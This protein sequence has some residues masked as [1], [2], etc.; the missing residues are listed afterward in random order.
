MSSIDRVALVLIAA[1]SMAACERDSG[2][3]SQSSSPPQ[4]AARITPQMDAAAQTID[5]EKLRRVIAEISDDRYGGRLPGTEGDTLARRYLAGE[6][7]RLGFASGAADGG[8]EQPVEL[9]GI[10]AQAPPVWRFDRGGFAVELERSTDF[11]AASGVQAE[12]A[13]IRDAELV[14]AGYAIQ[15]PE[16]DWDDF[17]DVDVRGKVLVVLNND[18]DWDPALF[19]G[20]TRLYYGRW[21]YKYE[22]AA[23]QGAA[24]V[25]IIHTTPS[26]GYPWQVVQTSWSG[27][28][29]ELPAGDEP[30]I[31]VQGWA[32]EEAARRLLGAEHDLDSLIE[33]AK[34]RDFRPVPLGI[35]T[36]LRLANTV[37]RTPTAN[38]YGVLRGSD[39]ALADQ[40][41]IYSAHFDHLGTVPPDAEGDTIANGARDNASGVSMLF[42]IGDAFKA[43]PEPPRRSIVLLFA[44]AEE[45]GLLGSQ[46]FAEHPPMPAGRIAAN[47]NYDSGNIWGQ[48]RDITY[49]GLGKSSLDAIALDVGTHQGLTV[50]PDQFPDR[51]FFYRSDQF[52]FAKV[53]VPAFYFRAGTD[54]VDRP[55]GWGAEQLQI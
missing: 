3:A 10:A 27:P 36:S 31:A 9:V 53:G 19:E 40:Y 18:P 22:S 12:A 30:R 38:V 51:G 15:A 23:R 2:T 45:Q 11:V 7:A 39:P 16:Y 49:I 35:T 52:N 48:A 33:Q 13:E 47:I 14:F 1:A 24:G 21:M 29:F 6:L 54:F 25:I 34:S 28:Q 50:K 43:L 4:A 20:T 26:A 5:G 44:A 42:A 37:T 46:Y 17:K 32:T 8:Y 41:V 55:A